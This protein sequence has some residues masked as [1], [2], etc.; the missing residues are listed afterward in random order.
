V[1]FRQTALFA[2]RAASRG[3]TIA[4][5]QQELADLWRPFFEVF[6][7]PFPQVRSCPDC[8]RGCCERKEMLERELPS[9]LAQPVG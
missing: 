1:V 7:L 5:C 3:H 2:V 8:R 4:R 9:N 6:G